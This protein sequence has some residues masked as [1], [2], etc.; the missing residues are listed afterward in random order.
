MT[1]I[2]LLA[3]V[4]VMLIGL[5]MVMH[6]REAAPPQRR[7]RVP[8]D[9]REVP[10]FRARDDYLEAQAWLNRVPRNPSERIP[11]AERYLTGSELAR[12]RELAQ[13]YKPDSPFY[14]SYNCTQVAVF[15]KFTE[16]DTR[17][18]LFDIQMTR[19]M[20]VYD[21]RTGALIRRQALEDC[22]KIYGLAYDP[23]LRRWKIERFYQ[24]FADVYT[25]NSAVLNTRMPLPPMAGHFN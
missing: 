14:E 25:A 13:V 22:V 10:Q 17:C 3:L 9:Q 4:L 5:L 2:L 18:M 15:R 12:F 7:T 19:V 1:V 6:G 16:G 8:L 24:E 20:A 21:R 23:V 11:Q